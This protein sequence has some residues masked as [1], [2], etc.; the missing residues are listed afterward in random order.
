MNNDNKEKRIKKVGEYLEQIFQSLNE[1]Y[2]KVNADF[3]GIEVDNYSL[4]KIPTSSIKETYIPGERFCRDTYTLRNRRAYSSNRLNNLKNIGYFEELEET[5]NSNN[6][7]G[8]L[9]DIDG[10]TSIQC[11]S[12]GTLKSTDKSEKTAVF[13]IQIQIEYMN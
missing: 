2:K 11:L 9:P 12:P 8:I 13:D 5:I 1:K 3:L 4:D 7:K 10:I 6:D